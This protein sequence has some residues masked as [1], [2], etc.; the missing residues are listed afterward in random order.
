MVQPA[1]GGSPPRWRRLCV[2]SVM[3]VVAL[4]QLVPPSA[5]TALVLHLAE[6]L[7]LLMGPFAQWGLMQGEGGGRREEGGCRWCGD[8]TADGVWVLAFGRLVQGLGGGGGGPQW[9]RLTRA[10]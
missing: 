2:Q 9:R 3:L 5:A 1:A 8:T 7:V 10:R 6:A 4:R